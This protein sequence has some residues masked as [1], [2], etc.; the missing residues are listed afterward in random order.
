MRRD[1][2]R[3]SCPEFPDLM[4]R[5]K[6]AARLCNLGL[7][8]DE[9]RFAAQ[10]WRI[11]RNFR[12]QGGKGATFQTKAETAR[13]SRPRR[14]R[15]GFPGQGGDGATFQTKAGSAPIS[16]QRRTR[17]DFPDQGVDTATNK[18]FLGTEV[19]TERFSVISKTFLFTSKNRK[20]IQALIVFT[21][22]PKKPCNLFGAVIY[23]H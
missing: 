16:R 15:R 21:K 17:R 9:A 18:Q 19:D 22:R 11:W 8:P 6:L 4:S 1:P 20:Q 2:W 5:L 3:D 10:P 13:L 14:R 23:N 12:D 7:N